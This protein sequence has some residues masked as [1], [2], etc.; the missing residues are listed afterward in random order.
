[1]YKNLLN[2]E[3]DTTKAIEIAPDIFWVG[4]V[5]PND[6]FQCHVYLIKNGD[7]SVLI[8]PGSM[9]TFPVTLQK[10][11]SVISLDQIKYVILHHQDPDIV[12]CVST[13]EQLIP[14][15]DVKFIT[16]WRAQTL[17]KHYQWKTPFWLVDEHDWKLTLKGGRELN[18]VFTPY[19]HFAGAF[20][21]YDAK[22]GTMF[23]SDIFGGLTEKFSLF[24]KDENYFESLKLF[25]IHYM[26]S[27]MILNHTLNH[28][29]RYNPT[30]IAPQHGS[31]IHQELIKPII[32]KMRDLDCGLYMLDDKESDILLLNKTEDLLNKFFEDILSL[33][34]FELI[35]R[36]LFDYIKHD[37]KSLNKMFVFKADTEDKELIFKV[38]EKSVFQEHTYTLEPKKEEWIS[39]TK[40]LKHN[41]ATIGEIE[42]IFQELS[43]KEKKFLD[44]FI[45]KILIPFSISFKKEISYENLREKSLTDPLTSLYNRE[46]LNEVLNDEMTNA[47]RKKT[48]LSIALIDI[49]YFKKINDTYG[50]ITGD[51]VLKE[52]AKILKKETRKSDIVVR[53]GG[54]EF[55]MIM[56][57]TDKTGAFSKI[58]R[59]RKFIQEYTFCEK[60]EKINLTISAGVLQYNNID[61]MQT[62]IQ[63]VDKNL[64]I[65]KS[66]G[67]NQTTA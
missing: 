30:L 12:G 67:R 5:I 3:V 47:K 26:P 28:I 20:C 1:M 57:L 32:K 62:F 48:P 35:L 53:Y 49:D 36:N 24:A 59:I 50:H 61:D 38:D 16:H 46:Y 31:I 39:Y 25:H 18:F 64:Y 19:A 4:Y 51:C 6:S 66:E 63:N 17:L 41:N 13:L 54:E 23:S 15:D 10:I 22:T 44:I 45:E 52:L 43:K 56:P 8:D 14:R 34:S 9:I 60:K 55:L 27:K 21:T 33:S 2:V 42:F 11:S 58:D 29:E 7:E 37:M 40:L 65:A